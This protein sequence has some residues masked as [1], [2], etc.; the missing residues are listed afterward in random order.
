M[1]YR[2]SHL[3]FLVPA[4]I[5]CSVSLASAGQ[6]DL[7][8]SQNLKNTFAEAGC[9][10]PPKRITLL[11]IKD[12]RRIEVWDMDG[13]GGPRLVKEYEIYAASGCRGPKLRK[14]DYQ[15]PEGVY[16]IVGLN[17]NSKYHLSIKL[18]YPNSFDREMAKC[19]GRDCIGGDIFIH[20]NHKSAGCLAVG[21]LGIEELYQ[22]VSD[23]G[24]G[25]VRVIITPHDF[26]KGEDVAGIA[27]ASPSWV[28]ALYRKLESE[29]SLY[30][31]SY[32][33]EAVQ[34][35]FSR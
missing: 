7:S 11:A 17:P 24:M 6:V 16:S 22:L 20:G 35:S 32:P 29:M 19:D 5:L 13:N 1:K 2:L 26:R 23:T 14:G 8:V 30:P 18:D 10:Y 4:I 28:P 27:D 15:V 9:N 34:V 3:K 21:D 31:R 12:E 25:R 33:P